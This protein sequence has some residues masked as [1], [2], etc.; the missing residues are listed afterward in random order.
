MFAVRF[1]AELLRHISL[2]SDARTPTPA[3]AVNVMI[4]RT[5]PTLATIG[6]AYPAPSLK[7][8]LTHA[9]LP[10]VLSSATTPAP[11]PPGATITRFPSTSGDSLSSQFGFSPL[12][13]LRMLRCQMTD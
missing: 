1:E 11:R 4:V 6:D 12:K 9:V 5:P 10:V 8:L 13:S 2:P 7:S 3:S